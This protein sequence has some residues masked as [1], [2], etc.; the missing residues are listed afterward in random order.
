[1]AQLII[2]LVQA[3]LGILQGS[4]VTISP[5]I[6][7]IVSS[8]TSAI[9]LLIAELRGGGGVT[10][11]ARAIIAGLQV[12]LTTLRA[13]GVLDQETEARLE[14]L[15]KALDAALDADS[16]AALAVD[17]EKLHPIQPL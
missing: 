7:G 6:L 13:T 5:N 2:V 12:Q 8:V 17:L 4:G 15:S 1:M 9:P 14:S 3:A 10:V 16:E 11:Q